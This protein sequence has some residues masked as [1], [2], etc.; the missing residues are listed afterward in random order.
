MKRVIA[1]MS[2][3]GGVGKTTVATMIAQILAEHAKTIIIDFDICGPSVCRALN[4]EGPLLKT[5]T[6]FTPVP[7]SENLDAITF[8]SILAPTD[9]VIW[10]GAKKL[11]FLDLFYNSAVNYTYVVIDTP[12]GISEEHEYLA[13]KQVEVIAVTTPQNISLNDTQRCIEFCKVNQ[14]PVLGLIENMSAV[15]CTSCNEIH[16][17]FGSKGGQDLASEYSLPFLGGLVI[18]PKLSEMI[19]DGTFNE[20]YRETDNYFVIRK[21]LED[22]KVI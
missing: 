13:K 21:M 3:K 15:K 7:V 9:A 14:I 8:G 20:K 19:D 6:G 18:E 4:V 2:G 10:R 12:P 16:H 5:A 11:I 1:V 22:L 17:P